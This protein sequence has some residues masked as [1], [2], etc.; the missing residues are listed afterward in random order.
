MFRQFFAV[1]DDRIPTP[2]RAQTPNHKVDPFL[3]WIKKI[4]MKA[5]SLAKIISVDEQTQQMQGHHPDKLRI[6]YKKEGDGFQFDALC[7]DGFI[8]TFYFQHELLPKK[9]TDQGLSALHARVMSMFDYVEDKNHTCG[10]DNLYISAK[11]CKDAYQH[12]HRILLYGVARKVTGDYQT[13]SYKKRSQIR[14][15]K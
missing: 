5:W 11:F 10:V 2:P 13:A 3:D 7:N 8:F 6:T 1:Q 9:Y 4:S 12:P 14:R 15:N